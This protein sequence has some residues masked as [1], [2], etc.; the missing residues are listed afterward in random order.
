MPSLQGGSVKS[1]LP[2]RASRCVRT[3]LIAISLAAAM[4]STAQTQTFTLRPTTPRLA[5]VGPEGRTEAQQAMLASRPDYNIYKTLAHHP[6]LYARWSPLGQFLLN[7]SSLPA[8]DRE[9]VMLRMGWL[10]QAEYEWAQHARIAKA[11]AGMND[12]EI[13]RIAEGPDAP[14]WSEFERTLLRMVDELRYE[15]MI[16]D[17][18][19]RALQTKYSVQQ[20][21]EALFTAAQYQLVS[22]ALNTLGV[23]L[24]PELE[25]R[26]PKDISLP[27]VASRPTTPRLEQP[28]LPPLSLNEMTP[29]QRELVQPQVRNGTLLNLYA[30]M[31]HHPKLYGP[32]VRFGSYLQR[33]SLLPPKTR[34]LLIL[35]T[36]HLI[37]AEYEWAHHVGP[38]KAAGFTDAEIA[39]IKDGPG[40]AGWSEEHRALLQAADELR[41]EAFIT[42]ETW[43]TLQKYYDTKQLIEIVYTVGGYTMTGLAINSLG[44]QAEK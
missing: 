9:I 4:T 39:R 26:L 17:A 15:A 8:R 37:A 10:C 7:G 2:G 33:D 13:H 12:A 5:P 18:T 19:W 1:L 20:I 6:D 35:R 28:R 31:A 24:D 23:Q 43:A 44:I 36:A 41:R 14:G 29:E 16:S 21:M 38:A 32:R 27:K 3:L 42:N 30:T 34:E 22:M 11:S 40:A 25:D